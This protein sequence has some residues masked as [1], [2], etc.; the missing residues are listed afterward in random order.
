MNGRSSFS[1]S[2]DNKCMTIH[3]RYQDGQPD[4]IQR[5]PLDEGD[6]IEVSYTGPSGETCS[7]GISRVKG[8]VQYLE[9]ACD[10]EG[11]MPAEVSQQTPQ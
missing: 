9:S 11:M 5:V 8:E 4:Q 3:H 1:I 6:S 2:V 7:M 10:T